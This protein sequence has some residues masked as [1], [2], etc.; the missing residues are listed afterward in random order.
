MP[1]E[2]DRE[3]F[4]SV[5]ETHSMLISRD[6]HGHGKFG[7]VAAILHALIITQAQMGPNGTG[8]YGWQQNAMTLVRRWG[9]GA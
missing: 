1:R 3:Y 7:R 5:E 4:D 2:L 8:T 6:G 9:L